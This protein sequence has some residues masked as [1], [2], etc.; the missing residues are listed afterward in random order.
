MFRLAIFLSIFLSGESKTAAT[1]SIAAVEQR[2]LDSRLAIQRWHIV[3]RFSRELVQP[4]ERPTAT[5]YWKDGERRRTDTTWAYASSEKAL[6]I[7]EETYKIVRIHGDDT[8]ITYGTKKYPNGKRDALTVRALELVP[9]PEEGDSVDDSIRFLGLMPMPILAGDVKMF[10]G[11]PKRTQLSMID[12]EWN[13]RV[14]R[15]ISYSLNG[16]EVRYWI[17]P[18]LG[19]SV[20]RTEA[21]TRSGESTLIRSENDIVLE[22]DEKTGIWFPVSVDYRM[23]RNDEVTKK[24]SVQVEVR[25]LNQPLSSRSFGL[26]DLDL[27]VGC[28]VYRIPESADANFIWDGKEI[29]REA[30]ESLEERK[31]RQPILVLGGGF[32]TMVCLVCLWRY[33]L[34]RQR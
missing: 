30:R 23:W 1:D 5:E 34:I 9:R 6:G 24:E 12:D 25:S 18:D 21:E 16:A 14:S 29:V 4:E 17:V 27:P 2:I 11:N 28:R 15:K 19:Y 7:A 22:R 3:V 32:L 10:F 13:G 26:A 31:P 33:F 8:F 20:I